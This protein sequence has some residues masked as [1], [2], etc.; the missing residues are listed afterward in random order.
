MAAHEVVDGWD[1]DGARGVKIAFLGGAEF[2]VEALF[3]GCVCGP[4]G[5]VDIGLFCM[6]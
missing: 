4:D 5:G 3:A 1:G 6:W 2:A